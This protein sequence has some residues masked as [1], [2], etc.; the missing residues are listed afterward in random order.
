MAVN[1]RAAKRD[2]NEPAIKAALRKVGATVVSLS[3]E[4]VPDLLV[5]FRGENFLLEV[6]M[7]KGELS[8]GQATWHMKWNGYPVHVVRSEEEALQAI[9]ATL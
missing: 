1:R 7:P 5:G 4:D 3:I 8:E 2:A 6:K 9:G